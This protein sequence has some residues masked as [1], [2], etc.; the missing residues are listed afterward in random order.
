MLSIHRGSSSRGL[1]ESPR[2]W[3]LSYV[4]L[5]EAVM[6]LE[7]GVCTFSMEDTGAQQQQ[8]QNPSPNVLESLYSLSPGLDATNSDYSASSEASSLSGRLMHGSVALTRR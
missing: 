7:L 6:M 2:A 3:R 5:Q 1:Q 4:R 8:Q